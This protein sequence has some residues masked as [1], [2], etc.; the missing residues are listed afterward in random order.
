MAMEAIEAQDI[1]D[2][3]VSVI[4][5]YFMSFWPE[6]LSVTSLQFKEKIRSN[7]EYFI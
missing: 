7:R 3:N 2:M 1:G 4:K 6:L 5:L